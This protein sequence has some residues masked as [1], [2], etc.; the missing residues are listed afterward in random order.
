MLYSR[1]DYVKEDDIHICDPGLDHKTS[2]KG[3]IFEIE[4]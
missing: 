2:Q 3:N 4:I 1:Y